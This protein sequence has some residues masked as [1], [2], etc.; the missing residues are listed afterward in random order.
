MPAV[1]TLTVLE[2]E[3]PFESLYVIVHEPAF[4]GVTVTLNDGPDADVGE[5]EATG[6]FPELHVVEIETVPE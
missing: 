6:A 3:R 2:R 1:E 5:I 4:C